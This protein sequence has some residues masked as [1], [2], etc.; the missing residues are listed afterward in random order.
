MFLARKI[1]RAKWETM[2]GLSAGEIPADAVTIDLKTQGNSLSFW[3][4]PTDARGDVDEAALAIAVA[5]ERLD[6]L[7]IIW[8][9]NE[10]L[11]ADGQTLRNTEGRTPVTDMATKHVD[12]TGLDYGRL[13]GVARR[14]VAAIEEDRYCRLT[15]ASVKRL[16]EAAVGQGRIDLDALDDRL[17]SEVAG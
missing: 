16:I 8:L 13:G 9:D 7:D 15:R 11:Q 14:V 5:R 1:T 12:V 3:Q 10:E 4:C 2:H 6:R 17:R